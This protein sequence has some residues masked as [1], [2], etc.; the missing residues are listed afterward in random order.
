MNVY[1][2]YYTIYA[3]IQWYTFLKYKSM[4]KRQILN[5]NVS[6]INSVLHILNYVQR[7]E[8]RLNPKFK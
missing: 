5:F 7:S 2:T 1:F 8:L 3:W 6:Y 4:I